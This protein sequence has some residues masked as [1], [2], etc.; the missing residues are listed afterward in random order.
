MHLQEISISENE[1]RDLLIKDLSVIESGL[2]YMAHEYS[3][4]GE[5]GSGGRIDILAK[6][7]YDHTVIIEIKRSEVAA[8]QALHEITKY[9]QIGKLKPDEC[10]VLLV[11]TSWSELSSSL[12]LYQEKIDHP[13]ESYLLSIVGEQL[14]VG[15]QYIEKPKV[16][17]LSYH[18]EHLQLVYDNTEDASKAFH[19]LKSLMD[20]HSV[21][22]AVVFLKNPKAFE[23][24]KARIYLISSSGW[25]S[26]T[27]HNAQVLIEETGLTQGRDS[28]DGPYN[29]YED[30]IN[31]LARPFSLSCLELDRGTPQKLRNY[32]CVFEVKGHHFSKEFVRRFPLHDIIDLINLASNKKAGGKTTLRTQ[33][34]SKHVASFEKNLNAIRAFLRHRQNWIEVIDERI[35]EKLKELGTIEV[36]IQIHDR[37]NIIGSMVDFHRNK[38]GRE[39]PHYRMLINNAAGE[40]VLDL[41]GI[42][43]WSGELMVKSPQE[44][45]A[46]LGTSYIIGFAGGYSSHDEQICKRLGLFPLSVQREP[47][48]IIYSHG[49]LLPSTIKDFSNFYETH[50]GWIDDITKEV[51]F[52]A[53]G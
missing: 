20:R 23:E 27:K 30:Y 48:P 36:D 15:R 24:V 38:D 14:K 34:S 40:M 37:R 12:A 7:K 33:F 41:Y 42:F 43:F 26:E 35:E 16:Y 6:D 1:I 32:E 25:D 31:A 46:E 4:P 18:K 19:A 44:Y 17:E 28:A 49:A 52:L 53:I 9:L 3:I 51:T 39:L 8:R 45:F 5:G 21:P 50:S 47:E 11:S 22:V 2:R 10:R 13:V 29:I